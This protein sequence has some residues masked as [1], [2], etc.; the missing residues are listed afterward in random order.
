MCPEDL[1]LLITSIAI[2]IA[3]EQ[4]AELVAVYAAA[5]TMLGD[6]LATYLTQSEFLE[7]LCQKQDE[8]NTV[9]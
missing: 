4:P 8:S 5:F 9:C 7:D 3:K 6:A 2:L 1:L